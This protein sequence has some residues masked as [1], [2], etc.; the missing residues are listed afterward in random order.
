MRGR[1]LSASMDVCVCVGGGLCEQ[2]SPA[3]DLLPMRP[4]WFIYCALIQPLSAH[5]HTNTHRWRNQHRIPRFCKCSVYFFST[6]DKTSTRKW[7]LVRGNRSV[8]LSHTALASYFLLHF[9]A[10]LSSSHFSSFSRTNVCL[11]PLFSHPHP[12]CA[13]PSHILYRPDWRV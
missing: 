9:S 8:T 12:P 2:A 10:S 5:S 11:S 7:H 4:P 13:F 1:G 6:R 3:G